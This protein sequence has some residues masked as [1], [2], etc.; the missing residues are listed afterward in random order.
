MIK[1]GLTGG[2]ATGKS[3]VSQMFKDKQIPVIDTDQIARDLFEKDTDTYHQIIDVFG[4]DVLHTDQ[5]INRKKLASIIF[6]NPQKRK[7]LNQIV[8]PKVREIVEEEIQKHMALGT[9]IIV[10]DVPLLFETNYD[11][12]VDKTIVVYTTKKEQIRR[13]MMRDN[14]DKE[15]AQMKINAQMSLTE[16]VDRADYVVNNSYSILNT[17]KDFNKILKDLEVM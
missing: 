9:K 11:E 7:K 17:K 6:P 13:L 3:T 10:I 15:Y 14:I 5:T 8:H 4:E 16:K 2:I 12:I 1:L